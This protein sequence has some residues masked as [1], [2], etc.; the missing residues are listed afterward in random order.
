MKY[1][2]NAIN[3]AI[4]ALGRMALDNAKEN[5]PV[6]TGRLRNSIR[7]KDAYNR[8]ANETTVMIGTNVEY[9]K[10]VELGGR[11]NAPAN[12]LGGA[13]KYAEEQAPAVFSVYMRGYDM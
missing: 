9:A 12:F 2:A 10:Y 3:A 1:P 6:R 8:A 7:M 4:K 13:A 5:C 11:K